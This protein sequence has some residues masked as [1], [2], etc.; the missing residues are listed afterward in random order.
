[1]D[2]NGKSKYESPILVSLGAL[3]KGSGVCTTGSSVV[4]GGGGNGDGDGD[5]EGTCEAGTCPGPFGLTTC[6]NTGTSPVDYCDAGSCAIQNGAS[7]CSAGAVA[8]PT[9]YCTAGNSGSTCVDG[10]NAVT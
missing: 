2:T 10:A 4:G 9:A 1:M 8:S 3:A 5:G 7:Y 6:S